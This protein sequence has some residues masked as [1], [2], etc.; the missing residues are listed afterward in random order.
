[1]LTPAEIEE[2]ARRD[3][4][5][6]RA[7]HFLT[8]PLSKLPPPGLLWAWQVDEAERFCGW[9]T[10]ALQRRFG[11]NADVEPLMGESGAIELLEIRAGDGSVVCD[12]RR[13]NRMQWMGSFCVMSNRALLGQGLQAV[14]LGTGG[15]DTVV[16]FCRR[17]W[18]DDLE[19]L[20]P[21]GG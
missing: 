15:E 7:P 16:A 1:M 18:A 9:A 19:E 10:R 11:V 6:E 13:L 2:A 4:T 14:E 20:F 8:W 12:W 21:S 5:F 3:P 17:R